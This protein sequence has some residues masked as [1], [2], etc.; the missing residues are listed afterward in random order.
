MNRQ[1]RYRGKRKGFPQQKNSYVQTMQNGFFKA[2]FFFLA[3]VVSRL[4][5]GVELSAL[6]PASWADAWPIKRRAS[7]CLHLKH[8]PCVHRFCQRGYVGGLE[9][10]KP[11]LYSCGTN[12][13]ILVLRSTNPIPSKTS[14]QLLNLIN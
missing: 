14:V 6:A 11:L 2:F 13:S 7:I 9:F 12:P 8:A 5:I 1:R 10:Y 3:S 4:I